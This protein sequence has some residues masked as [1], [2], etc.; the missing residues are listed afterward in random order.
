M[1][2]GSGAERS[3]RR[4]LCTPELSPKAIKEPRRLV[5][6]GDGCPGRTNTSAGIRG[7][8]IQTFL[9]GC[10]GINNGDAHTRDRHAK[11]SCL[12]RA[13]SDAFARHARQGCRSCLFWCLLSRGRER[14]VEV[15]EVQVVDA[16]GARCFPDGDLAVC[17]S[18]DGTA[19][20]FRRRRPH[21]RNSRPKAC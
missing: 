11:A 7:H 5:S 10:L 15:V 19:G 2:R 8:E 4:R 14:L 13:G 6:E 1:C 20:V 16:V 3:L 18:V 21:R 9:L 17:A 12:G